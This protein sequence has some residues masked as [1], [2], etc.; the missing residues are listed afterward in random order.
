[1]KDY[2][3]KHKFIETVQNYRQNKRNYKTKI[4]K[5]QHITESLFD[6][7]ACECKKEALS[8]CPKEVKSIKDE[9]VFLVD[10][11]SVRKVIIGS[12]DWKKPAQMQK[13]SIRKQLDFIRKDK[14]TKAEESELSIE[15]K[16]FSLPESETDTYASGK[17]FPILSLINFQ[18]V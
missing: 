18:L 5:F 10:Q 13:R 16:Y 12:I 15:I 1:M 8:G 17:K 14:R 3:D 4:A 7:C 9:K 2:H 11:R 6:I